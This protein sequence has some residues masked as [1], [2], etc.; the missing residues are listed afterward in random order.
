MAVSPFEAK[1]DTRKQR[2]HSFFD[3]SAR[4]KKTLQLQGFGARDLA[5]PFLTTQKD[6]ES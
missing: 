2:R 5:H 3:R 6:A 4:D 1:G